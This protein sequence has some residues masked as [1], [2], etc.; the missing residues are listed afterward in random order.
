MYID[1]RR[2]GFKV[3]YFFGKLQIL[4]IRMGNALVYVNKEM[5]MKLVFIGD[6]NGMEIQLTLNWRSFYLGLKALL[7]IIAAILSL[8]ATSDIERLLI[9]V[10]R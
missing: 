6:E 3:P 2:C 5:Q 9:M 4:L 8:L 10:S 7:P 1:V